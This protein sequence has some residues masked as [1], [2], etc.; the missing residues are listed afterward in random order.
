MIDVLAVDLGGVA[1][2]FYPERRRAALAALTG[3]AEITI[4]TRWFTSGHE[5]EAELGAYSTDT[6]AGAIQA[7]L[8]VEVAV[9]D[10]VKAWSLAFEPEVEVLEL[11]AA[12]PA[13]RVLFTNNGPM[14]DL[15]F[16]GP[17]R[18][19][20]SAF[21]PPLASWRIGARKPSEA[22]FERAAALLNVPPGRILLVDDALPNVLAARQ[23]GW[24]AAHT[25][26]TALV[27]SALR[28]AGLEP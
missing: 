5:G 11:L 16:A 12:I 17:L 20:G 22:A 24:Q 1:A 19:L 28:D 9:S 21:G 10:L 25:P 4:E 14:V 18:D 2:R 13:R 26:N 7:A 8:G 6:I 23:C 27:R 15:C 3:L